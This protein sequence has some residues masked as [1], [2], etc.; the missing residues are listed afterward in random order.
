MKLP[1]KIP[2]IKLPS[3]KLPKFGK[4]KSGDGE[5]DEDEDFDFDT[6]E[7]EDETGGAS[8]D[9]DESVEP[10]APE[11]SGDEKAE[12]PQAESD[13]ENGGSGDDEDDDLGLDDIDFDDDDDDDDD[14][15]EEKKGGLDKRKLLLFGGGTAA[16][17][18]IGGLSWFFLSG[19]DGGENAAGND[20]GIPKV[21]MTIT[22]KKKP[23]AFGGAKS[24]NDLGSKPGSEEEP[25]SLNTLGSSATP[26][27]STG[28]LVP[29]V[30]AHSF[31]SIKPPAVVDAALEGVDIPLMQEESPQGPLP[32]IGDDGRQPWQVFAK[33]FQKTDERPQVAIV[34]GGLGLSA[35][36]SEAA[37]R[38]LPGNVT[39]AFSPYAEGLQD[40]VAKA[41][42][43]GHEVMIMMPLEPDT[44]PVIDPGPQTLLTSNAPEENQMRLEYVLSCVTSYMG[45]M[46]VRGSRFNTSDEHLRAFLGEL[47][48]RGL[49]FF[50]GM[51]DPKSMG[52]EIATEL[53]LPRAF[54]DIVLDTIPTRTAIDAQLDEL[55]GVLSGQ[56]AAVAVAEAYPSSIER[57]AAWTAGLDAKNLALVPVSALANKQTLK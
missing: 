3:I 5:D 45:V 37:I 54:A 56:A 19:D 13:G 38:L 9:G 21:T 12:S 28:A 53:T 15:D 24:L 11:D 23:G 36:A 55:E 25:S 33:P 17:L 49:M 22:P 42:Q 30:P 27:T 43:A 16:L 52:P 41:R 7:F 51:V 31:A 35:T 26:G 18:L 48:N 8:D 47:K 10:P 6:S 32:K 29:V 40:W 57:L 46:T 34:V 1:F 2:G 44:F 4:K 50:E 39:L 14:D 20:S